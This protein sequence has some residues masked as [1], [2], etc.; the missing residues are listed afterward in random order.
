MRSTCNRDSVG[1]NPTPGCSP[2]VR[3]SAPTPD[4][5]TALRGGA[6]RPARTGPDRHR[7]RRRS[8]RRACGVA[9]GPRSIATGPVSPGRRV[10]AHGS[11][12]GRFGTRRTPFSDRPPESARRGRTAAPRRPWSAPR[13]S[14]RTAAGG[15]RRAVWARHRHRA[16]SRAGSFRE[17]RCEPSRGSP[18]VHD[19]ARDP[20][21]ENE[22]HT[23]RRCRPRSESRGRPG[24]ASESGHAPRTAHL[25][26][27]APWRPFLPDG[28]L[29]RLRAHAR[30]TPSVPVRTSSRHRSCRATGDSPDACRSFPRRCS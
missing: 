17:P 8:S 12:R 15:G 24:P 25:R 6:A 5:P 20:W 11:H 7:H 27:R 23:T 13:R 2:N 16:D 21:T 26:H 10:V 1:S 14:C 29:A 4:D 22:T 19:P 3:G 18:W 9:Y 28:S 30:R